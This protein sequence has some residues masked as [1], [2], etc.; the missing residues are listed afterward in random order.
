[1]TDMLQS[2]ANTKSVAGCWRFSEISTLCRATATVVLEIWPESGG[3]Q[4][5]G[6]SGVNKGSEG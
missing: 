3:G 2:H 5:G 6:Y 1:M 4:A